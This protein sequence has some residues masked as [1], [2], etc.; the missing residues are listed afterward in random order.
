MDVLEL[1]ILTGV[2]VSVIS[3]IFVFG[4]SLFSSSKS[5]GML[6]RCIESV[7]EKPGTSKVVCAYVPSDVYVCSERHNCIKTA[8]GLIYTFPNFVDIEI[9]GGVIPTGLH[10][11]KCVSEISQVNVSSSSV[12]FIITLRIKVIT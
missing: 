9:E 1:V 11:I 7:V 12:S 3:M 10:Y 4:M 2:A 8:S 6:V 5:L